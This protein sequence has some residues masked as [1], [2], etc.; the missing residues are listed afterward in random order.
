MSAHL[1]PPSVSVGRDS[2]FHNACPTPKEE[3]TAVSRQKNYLLAN[4]E[5]LNPCAN[6]RHETNKIYCGA[7]AVG[8]EL[9]CL[10]TA[11]PWDIIRFQGGWGG[12]DEELLSPLSGR[13]RREHQRVHVVPAPDYRFLAEESQAGHG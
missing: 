2:L 13:V 8:W 3:T 5:I 6:P 7:A 1:Q 4:A 9:D 11:V 10:L 12:R